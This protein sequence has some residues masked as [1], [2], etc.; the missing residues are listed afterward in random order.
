MQVINTALQAARPIVGAVA[1]LFGI[2]A[3]WLAVVE[4]MP[5]LSQVWRPRGTAQSHAIVGAC[6]A[7]VAGTR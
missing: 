4:L 2:L 5:V 6:L 7:I 1:L 3:A